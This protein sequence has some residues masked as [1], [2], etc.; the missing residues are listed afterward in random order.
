MNP[1]IEALLARVQKP[2]WYAGGELNSVVK[3]KA[4]VRI[5]FAFCFPDLYGNG[6]IAPLP[7]AI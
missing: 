5:R 7:S 2:G 3:D 1:S 6:K 4:S